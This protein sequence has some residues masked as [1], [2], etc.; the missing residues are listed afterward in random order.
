MTHYR[1]ECFGKLPLH[2]DFIRHQASPELLELDRWIQAGVG[3]AR[4]RPDWATSWPA[5]PPLRFL[6]HAPGA[7]LLAGVMVP[8]RD[9]A[10]RDYPFTV[11][12]AL[13]GK[14]LR[15]QPELA[16]LACEPFFA[17]AEE[18]A[19]RQWPAGAT[20]RD[21]QAALERLAGDLDL[22]A[23]ERR[24]AQVQAE[25][26]LQRLLSEELGAWDERRFLLLGNSASLLGP[27]SKPRF[28][29]ALPAGGEPARTAL[30]LALVTALRGGAAQF[31]PLLTW[32]TQPGAAGLRLVLVEPQG[33]HFLPLVLRHLPSDACD[34]AR[35]GLES[36]SLM[37]KARDRFAGLALPDA[38][39]GEL[40]PKLAAAA[41]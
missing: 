18:L 16:A 7:R 27:R 33:E 13:D 28:A 1:G 14:E 19:R 37:H 9:S 22:R 6:R 34:L 25:T 24:L 31:P 5:T 38:R 29:L 10:G 17:A 39:L 36:Q 20:Y 26:T 21:V 32:S 4:A 40:I 2:G 12:C 3:V 30:W 15:R 8:S 35:E 11:A 23:A 41:R